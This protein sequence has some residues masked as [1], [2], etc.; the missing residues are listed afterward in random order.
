[1]VFTLSNCGLLFQ[2]GTGGGV[3]RGGGGKGQE[4]E[5]NFM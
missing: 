4:A 1:M 2:R 3:G 5:Y